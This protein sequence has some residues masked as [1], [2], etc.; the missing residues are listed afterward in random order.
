MEFPLLLFVILVKGL[1]LNFTTFVEKSVWI[2]FIKNVLFQIKR[3]F[4]L[5]DMPA[6]K[7]SNRS[8]FY[9]G[10]KGIYFLHGLCVVET[11]VRI[12]DF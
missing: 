8:S 7:Y 3:I 4:S 1:Y 12:E 9:G 10:P 2:F 5:L 11:I 6:Q